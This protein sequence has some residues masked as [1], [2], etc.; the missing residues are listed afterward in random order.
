MEK[1]FIKNRHDKKLAVLLERP[2]SP[3]GL[4][5]LMHGL[6]SSKDFSH[7]RR[8]AGY[9]F[10]NSLIV[11]SFDARHTNGESDGRIEEAT[12]SNYYEDLEDVISWSEAQTWYQ[13]PF[14]LIGHSL[15]A[16]CVSLY[17]QNHS[18]KV[19][20]LAPL[21]LVIS[22]EL[23]FKAWG[24]DDQKKWRETGMKEWESSIKPGLINRVKYDFVPDALKYNL[25][26]EINKFKCP[27][28][29]IVGELDTATPVQQQ[30]MFFDKLSCPKEF[31]I[32]KGAGHTFSG[33]QYLQKLGETFG[34]WLKSL[35]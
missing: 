10:E 9:L 21:S 30:R 12:I 34:H 18:E 1:F 7:I 6:G 29:M 27:F 24:D 31:H 13:A 11:V 5:F 25:L 22:G 28:L 20:A 26:P 17:T 33:E 16:F 4:A 23:L 32:I 19:K 2:E 3:K 8:V 15:G 14:Y 35:N